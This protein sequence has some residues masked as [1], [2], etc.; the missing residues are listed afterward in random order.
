MEELLAILQEVR[1]DV[2]FTKEDKLIDNRILDSFDIVSLLS[3][4]NEKFKVNITVL[5]LTSEH[6]NSASAI[7]SLIDENKK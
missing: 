7:C 5:D 6:F 2:D 3:R 4:I 1:P